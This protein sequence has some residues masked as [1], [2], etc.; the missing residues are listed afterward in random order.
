MTSGAVTVHPDTQVTQIA[1]TLRENQ[2]HRVLVVERGL[3]CGIVSSFDLVA[4]L[5]SDSAH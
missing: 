3:L 2:I 1:R 5:E 4:L